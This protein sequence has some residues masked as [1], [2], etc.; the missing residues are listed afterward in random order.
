MHPSL[1]PSPF[2]AQEASLLS[3]AIS[4]SISGALFA[5]V[6]IPGG[7]VN[8]TPTW[9][10]PATGT[11]K[12]FVHIKAGGK[13][14]LAGCCRERKG[15]RDSRL[16]WRRARQLPPVLASALAL[17]PNSAVQRHL[18][19]LWAYLFCRRNRWRAFILLWELV[20]CV[21]LGLCV[22]GRISATH[23]VKLFLYKAALNFWAHACNLK[24]S[25]KLLLSAINSTFFR[26]SS[27]CSYIDTL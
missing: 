21:T 16:F 18:L 1:S 23:K 6:F 26:R 9:N 4:V 5:N 27:K 20:V 15:F 25:I 12:L 10:K 24:G 3:H 19:N 7:G 11:G 22:A 13:C 17:S 2:D 14:W 8:N